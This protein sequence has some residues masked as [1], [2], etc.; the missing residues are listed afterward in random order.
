MTISN[1][2][3]S[4]QIPG[5]STQILDYES[6]FE[7]LQAGNTVI[8]GNSRLSRVLTDQ[9]NQ[10][11]I[12]RGDSQWQ[13][14]QILSWNLWLDKLWETASLNGVAGTDRAVPGSR[15][16][17]SLWESILKNEPLAHDL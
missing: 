6:L 12:N 9:Y 15:Q 14:P 11:R 17:I 2:A 8:T 5:L 1:S 7:R 4:A 13:S 3:L 10:W 16:L